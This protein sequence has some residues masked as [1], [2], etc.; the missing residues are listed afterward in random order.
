MSNN[1]KGTKTEA[2]LKAAFSGESEARNKYSYYSSV[3]C[4]E[5]Y[6]Q[7]ANIFE[8]T[9]NNEKEHAKMWFKHL[10]GGKV[11]DTKTNLNDAASGENYEWT[12]MYAEFAKVAREEGFEDIAKE[13]EL[14]GTIE[15][16]H[17]ERY[18]TLLA[19]LETGK[20]FAR[21]DEKAWHC[22]NCGKTVTGKDA[23]DLCPVCSHPK[24]YF[25]IK[26][27]NY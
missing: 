12:T 26:A 6:V 15:K 7:V 5:G 9:A 4:K 13:F 10:H 23:P 8:E 19:N 16:E 18:K 11:P 21:A 25:E 2:N 27:D 1:L 22:L 20:V 24:A 14:V 3:A 17:E